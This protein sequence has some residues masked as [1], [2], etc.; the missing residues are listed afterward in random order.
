MLT[1]DA[2]NEYQVQKMHVSWET[3]LYNCLLCLPSIELKSTIAV[4]A[5]QD[6]L[7]AICQQVGFPTT[8]QKNENVQ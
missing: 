7:Q 1:P 8:I 4:L 6:I 5:C 2:K 3:W